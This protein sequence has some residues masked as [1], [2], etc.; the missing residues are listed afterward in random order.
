MAKVI[1]PNY[2][3]HECICNQ[4]PSPSLSEAQWTVGV[5]GRQYLS[6][7]S[8]CKPKFQRLINEQVFCLW[9]ELFNYESGHCVPSKPSKLYVHTHTRA[10]QWKHSQVNLATSLRTN[11]K[12]V[13]IKRILQSLIRIDACNTRF[14]R[15]NLSL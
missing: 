12:Q 9:I 8:D 3:W 11:R 14:N 15:A 4:P 1:N 2:D 7:L 13:Y 10:L 6:E 5:P